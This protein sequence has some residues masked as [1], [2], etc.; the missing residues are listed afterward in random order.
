[1]EYK[2]L[3]SLFIARRRWAN[4]GRSLSS[5][6][7]SLPCILPPSSCTNFLSHGVLN[8]S[9]LSQTCKGAGKSFLKLFACAEL[10]G[11][12]CYTECALHESAWVREQVGL[13]Y[14]LEKEKVTYSHLLA[15]KG[16]FSNWQGDSIWFL[17]LPFW[18]S[19]KLILKFDD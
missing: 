12:V 1:M 11:I 3:W 2:Y 9:V 19:Y 8:S 17:W 7:C 18:L 6:M 5:S 13:K 15:Q 10:P 16:S 14:I 4:K